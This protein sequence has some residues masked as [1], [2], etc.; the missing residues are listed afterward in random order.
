[1]PRICE[2][3]SNLDSD[4]SQLKESQRQSWD[5]VANGWQKWWVAFEHD[6][7]R[8]NQ[9]LVEL[10]S[11]AQHA[12]REGTAAANNIIS[13]I[14]KK[15][16]NKKV[17]DYKTKGMMAS[18]GKR[19]GVGA[20]LGIE[21]QGFLAWWIW[22]MYYLANLPTLQKK[23]RVIADWTLDI[24]FKRDVTMLKTVLEDVPGIDSKK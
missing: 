4:T 3:N 23:I 22:R 17:F 9:R 18:I 6:A 16:K 5:S 10:A 19:N 1:M 15:P 12:I 21:V 11:T 14:E 24:F 8:V 7:Q 2:S 20:I 13:L